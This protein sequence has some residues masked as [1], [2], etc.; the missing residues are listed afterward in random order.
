[1]L[2]LRRCAEARAEFSGHADLGE[3][4]R[5]APPYATSGSAELALRFG[6]DSQ[7]RPVLTGQ[8]EAAVE[9]E[10][11]RCLQRMTLSVTIPLSL[12]LVE[13][14][15]LGRRLEDEGEYLVIGNEPVRTLSLIEDE[16]LLALPMVPTHPGCKAAD[17]EQQE[18]PEQD[19]ETHRPFAGLSELRKQ[20]TKDEQE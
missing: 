9:A 14:E 20:Q 3:C 11:Q 18:A 2:D 10:C 5:L 16:L 19:T 17:T 1:M 12:F 7:H 6:R 13:S 8:V 4:E 15:A